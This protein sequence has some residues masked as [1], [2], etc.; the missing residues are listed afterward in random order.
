M[1]SERCSHYFSDPVATEE[2]ANTMEFAELAYRE[3]LEMVA[4]CFSYHFVEVLGLYH[5]KIWEVVLR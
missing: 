4:E 2:V 1:T 5:R 3:L